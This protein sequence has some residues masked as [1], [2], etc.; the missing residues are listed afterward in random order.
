MGPS[1]NIEKISQKF[2]DTHQGYLC[3]VVSVLHGCGSL[4][5]PGLG[6]DQTR[7][8]CVGAGGVSRG[9]DVSTHRGDHGAGGEVQGELGD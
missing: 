4:L 1:S 9:H 5:Q 8:L 6:G 3:L 7:L 2:V